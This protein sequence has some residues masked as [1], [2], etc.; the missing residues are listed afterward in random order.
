MKN[1][2][3][4]KRKTLIISSVIIVILLVVGYFVY[5]K[6]G[7][8]YE[9]NT[10]EV[11][12]QSRTSDDNY[13]PI[14]ND[15]KGYVI[16][17]NY[18]EY[19]KYY[20]EIL[21]YNH[22]YDLDNYS[23]NEEIEEI[24]ALKAIDP[25]ITKDFFTNNSLLI[26]KVSKTKVGIDMEINIGKITYHNDTINV[27][28]CGTYSSSVLFN[29]EVGKIYFIPIDNKINNA[30]IDVS[31]ELKEQS[32]H[33]PSIDKPIIYLYP[34]EETTINVVLGKPQNLLHTYP[35]YENSWNV[36]A[37][38]NGD[39]ID[40]KTN[41]N[42]YSLYW[43]GIN[44]VKPNMS[45]GFI[46]EGKDTIGFLEEKLDLLGLN[47]R[48]ANEFIIYWLPKLERNKYNFIRF[49]TNKEIADNMPLQI[50][51]NP[52]SII[53]VVMEFKGLDSYIDIPEQNIKTPLREGFVVVEWGG[54]EIS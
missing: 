1:I 18:A 5:N 11:K 17:K 13:S 43:E 38:P 10:Y 34:L 31:L 47:E 35:K 50:T 39:L 12:Y 19:Q 33:F 54:T 16:V 3:K 23:S 8:K 2:K 14:L 51:P 48:E 40:V 21:N 15:V 36:L 52:D 30:N 7:R 49:Q 4:D 29:N 20:N 27:N 37:K 6:F 41:R 26:F 45:E 24:K 32:N 28:I 46:V 25:K 22:Y 53:R 42:L 9:I 44:I